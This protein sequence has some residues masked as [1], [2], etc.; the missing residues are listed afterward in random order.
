MSLSQ[1]ED[2]LIVKIFVFLF[3]NSYAS[4]YYLAFLAESIGDCPVSGCMFTL[5]INLAVVFGSS[6]CSSCAVQLL[7]PYLAYQYQYYFSTHSRPFSEAACKYSSMNQ[8]SRPEEEHMMGVVSACALFLWQVLT[9]D[10][11]IYTVRPPLHRD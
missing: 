1:Y 7:L 2:S 5:A 4:F 8:I 11:A 9:S 3:V 6:L 10:F